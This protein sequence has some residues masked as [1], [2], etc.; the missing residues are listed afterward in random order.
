MFLSEYVLYIYRTEQP[1][2]PTMTRSE[3]SSP[4]EGYTIECDAKSTSLPS[5]L[6]RPITYTWSTNNENANV[7]YTVT[8]QHNDTFSIDSRDANEEYL[9]EVTCEA[10]E[11]GSPYSSQDTTSVHFEGINMS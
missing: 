11:E 6:A 10:R 7:G 3:P 8:G 9:I 1:L 4:S 2:P 5:N